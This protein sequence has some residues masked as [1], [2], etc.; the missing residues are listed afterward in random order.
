ME[1]SGSM[2]LQPVDSAELLS[3]VKCLESNKAAGHDDISPKVIKA[4]IDVISQ[5]LVDI[6]NNSLLAG[7]FPDDLKIA[8]V[9]PI[10]KADD[11]VLV[12]NYRP[13]SV[14]PVFS[15]I[16]E[17]LMHNRL[18]KYLNSMNIITDKQFGF[19]EKHST[20]MA[21]LKII[22]KISDEIDKKKL[23]LG[24]FIDL[25]KAFDTI[26]HQIML[27][28]LHHY[29]IRGIAHNWL[30]SYLSNRK[31]YVQIKSHK[32]CL[33]PITCGVPQGSILGPLLF[34]IYIND[35]VNVSNLINLIMF[36]DD[37]NIF[38]TDN[39]LNGL[40][41]KTNQELD[42]ISKW[43]KLNKLSLN[44]KK[45]NFILFH[46]KSKVIRYVPTIT[47]DNIPI[48]QV[49]E[50][51]FLGVVINESLSWINHIDTI[52]QKVTKNIGIIRR[53]KSN[54]PM[55]VLKTLYQTLIQP[56]FEYCNIVWSIH[57]SS[58]LNNLMICQK[59]A[60]RVI[61]NSKWNAHTK[62]LFYKTRILPID[63]LNDLHV[64]CFMYR[65]LHNMLPQYF[66]SMFVTNAEIHSHNTRNKENI[67]LISHRL[68][69]RKFTIRI[70]GPNIWNFTP[71]NIRNSPSIHIFKRRYK[72]TLMSTLTSS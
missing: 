28:K 48:V 63:K 2:F 8:K 30:A 34:I 61:T 45:T 55:C 57:K 22:D 25:S 31:Q 9:S 12:S 17:K 27:N 23:S 66:C 70:H 10:F 60:I 35:I 37:T 38:F 59:K 64:A 50:T 43:F 67:H 15:K 44:V 62:P 47:I 4:T 42:K 49:K 1:N 26:N 53:I 18:V 32:S 7:V 69:L 68:D 52:K 21:I 3:I 54:I 40:E 11:K 13:I 24:I 36:A 39:T 65:S 33:L 6:F 58:A 46:T 14:L 29:G 72:E 51:K 19:R 20:F 56:Y 71:I 5:P 41:S 16:L